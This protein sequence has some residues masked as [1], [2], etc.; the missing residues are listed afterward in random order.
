MTLKKH[1][2]QLLKSQLDDKS[3]KVELEKA[4]NKFKH[5]NKTSTNKNEIN[6]NTKSNES[7]EAQKKPKLSKA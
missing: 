4:L 3:G 1:V 6:E 7:K 5:E 2:K